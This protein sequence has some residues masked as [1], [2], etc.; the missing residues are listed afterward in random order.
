MK[1]ASPSW[2][3][4]Q[5][6]LFPTQI[7]LKCC[8][9]DG[10]WVCLTEAGLW[11]ESAGDT[12]GDAFKFAWEL[13]LISN[14][15]YIFFFCLTGSS[16]VSSEG[17]LKSLEVH[18]GSVKECEHSSVYLLPSFIPSLPVVQI[19]GKSLQRVDS[20]L[21]FPI[22]PGMRCLGLP[23]EGYP[24]IFASGSVPLKEPWNTLHSCRFMSAV[25][26]SRAFLTYSCKLIMGTPSGPCR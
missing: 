14:D 13:D 17:T 26:P 1:P 21:R 3:C 6:P 25:Y 11:L 22:P 24:A 8:K 16:L 12:S 9:P 4:E 18:F 10:G 7:V 23:H 5:L 15:E 19:R 2:V 20:S